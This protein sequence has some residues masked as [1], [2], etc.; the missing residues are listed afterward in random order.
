MKQ[1]LGEI[2]FL[3]AALAAF[4][5]LCFAVAPPGLYSNEEGVYYVQMR[6]FA[7]NGSFEIA[8]PGFRLGF[9][10][11]DLSGQGGFFESRGSRLYAIT[12]PLFPWISSLL[13]PILGEGAVDFAPI[14][15]MVLSALVLGMTLDRVMPRGVLYFIL[16]ASFLI[17]SPVLLLAY[18]FSGQSLGLILLVSGLFLLVRHFGTESPSRGGLAGSSFLVAAAVLAGFE[19]LFVAVSFLLAAGAVF[20]IQKRWAELASVAA[21][22]ALALAILV[23]H[24]SILYGCFPGPYLRKMLPYYEFSGLR[25]AVLAGCFITSGILFAAS[26]KEG[27][28]P[29]M[30]AVLT[31]LPVVL[32]LVTVSISAAR[33]TV[34]HLMA[35]FPL[36]L[37]SFYGLPGHMDRLMKREGVIQAILPLTVILC[38]FLGASIYRPNPG[39]ILAVWLPLVP[40]VILLL[41]AEHRRIFDDSKGMFVVLLFF[42]GVALLNNLQELRSDLWLYKDYNDR[43]IEFLRQH[44]SGSD[45]VLFYDHASMEH[46]GPLFFEKVFLV[47]SRPGDQ[48]RFTRQLAERG[49]G[50]ACAWTLDPFRD[51]RGFDPYGHDSMQKFPFPSERS[52]C[53]GGSC[54]ERSFYLIRLNTGADRPGGAGR[55]GA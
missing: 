13:Y 34:S 25:S 43:R 33:I 29:L 30:R 32:L 3:S 20:C 51:V 46:A 11:D 47:A 44:T 49:H 31:V 48:E 36:V 24:D 39:M 14:L 8:W 21:G 37:F 54:R 4:A 16:M 9:S 28:G 26:R 23:L 5:G 1:R 27:I 10:A 40:F 55:G 7:L 52:A 6:N 17:G 45:A 50:S 53:C 22:A 15:F 18:K 35:V 2:I 19:F 41:G 12:P 38:L 42:G